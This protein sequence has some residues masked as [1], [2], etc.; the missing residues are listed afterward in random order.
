MFSRYTPAVSHFGWGSRG[1]ATGAEF[2]GNG[3]S[4]ITGLISRKGN[5]CCKVYRRRTTGFF[6]GYVCHDNHSLLFCR[7]PFAGLVVIMRPAIGPV[8]N[9]FNFFFL[10][11]H[12]KACELH[13]YKW[14]GPK[15]LYVLQVLVVRIP[16]RSL[17]SAHI[18]HL[19]FRF[20]R[21]FLLLPLVVHVLNDTDDRP[22]ASL[23]GF[24]F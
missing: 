4:V 7:A 6:K 19:T 13:N 15:I 17:I 8:N 12:G 20:L 23:S 16:Q 1:N 5:N 10:V 9:Y 2:I 24:S 22:T 3:A 18:P 11:G 21:R 14:N